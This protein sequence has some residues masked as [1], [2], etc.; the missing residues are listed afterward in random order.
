MRAWNTSTEHAGICPW[1]TTVVWSV[2]CVSVTSVYCQCVRLQWMKNRDGAPTSH[3]GPG[4]LRQKRLSPNYQL[5]LPASPSAQ[6]LTA[7]QLSP[8]SRQSLQKWT[9]Q[10]NPVLLGDTHT[11]THTYAGLIQQALKRFY[12]LFLLF[13]IS[14]AKEKSKIKWR[15]HTGRDSRA[16]KKLIT[17]TK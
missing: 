7:A 8:S 4:G 11:H 17:K 2:K 10:L 6:H 16:N 12:Q 3:G 1:Q 13:Y 14:G 5:R 9:A 15:D